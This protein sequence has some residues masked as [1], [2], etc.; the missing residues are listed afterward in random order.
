M[1]RDQYWIYT[2]GK[3]FLLMLFQI[4]DADISYHEV[5]NV[6]LKVHDNYNLYFR[7]TPII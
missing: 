2:L 3:G 4:S 5:V 1:E 7:Y 6:S